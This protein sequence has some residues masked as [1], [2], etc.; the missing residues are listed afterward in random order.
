MVAIPGGWNYGDVLDALADA[1]PP[2]DPALIHGE[3]VI[4]WGEFTRRTNNLAR[5][6]RARGAGAD[7]KIA[8][9]LRNHP[10][11]MEGVSAAFKARLV[12]VN[13]NY[14]Y[15]DEELHYIL[16]NS[17]AKVVVY[18]AEF[19][20]HVRQ[21]KDRLPKVAVWV[22]VT[23]DGS[24]A[25]AGALDHEALCETGDGAPLG[26]ERSGDDLL[27][28]YTGG[29]TGMPKGV[30]WRQDDHWHAGSAGA[31]PATD[32]VPPASLADHVENVRRAGGGGRLLPCCPQMHGT[33]LFTSIGALAA[34]GSVVTL[35]GPGFDAAEC[36][37]AVT[38]W[39][40]NTLAI[41]GDAFAKPI[42]R[43]LE[44]NGNRYDLG[45]VVVMIS[46]GVMWSMEVKQGLLRHNPAMVLADSFGAA[47]AVGV[48]RGDTAAEGTVQ[49]ARFVL[50]EHC[51]VFTEDLREVKPGDPEPGFI[52]RGGAIPLGY[53]KDEEKTRKTFPII[54]GQ[55]WSMPGDWVRVEADGGLVLLGRGSVCINTAGEKVYPEEVEEVLKAH[56]DVDD[57]LVVGVPDEQWGQMVTAVVQLR[58]GVGLDEA[59]LRSHVR[60]HLAGYKAPKRILARDTLGRASNGKADYK[61]VTAYA[62]E[63]LALPRT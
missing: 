63:Q 44:A 60:E 58:D 27:L 29:T 47:G 7:D 57:A 48:G 36:L 3:R 19:A 9:Y 23:E 25:V 4:R 37:E 5:A 31:T 30:M 46:S 62:K 33:G 59:A 18:G 54:D 43:E 10:A 61:L 32:M 24:P 13:V 1:V 2:D 21:L 11:Y 8:F 51:K 39:Q 45:S 22:E 41:V 42:L 55:R 20:E 6:L 28:L 53:Y 26:I 52:A 15:V 35:D 16:D 12:H 14:R 56:P 40:V 49:T 34:G 50:G 17:D 38:R